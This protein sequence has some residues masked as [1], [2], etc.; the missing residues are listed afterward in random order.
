MFSKNTPSTEI[1]IS[2]SPS[3]SLPKP[4]LIDED[5]ARLLREG[6][7]SKSQSHPWITD[8]QNIYIDQCIQALQ[9]FRF[10]SNFIEQFNERWDISNIRAALFHTKLEPLARVIKAFLKKD[11]YP[12]ISYF[13]SDEQKPGSYISCNFHPDFLNLFDDIKHR[14]TVI[15]NLKIAVQMLSDKEKIYVKKR[16]SHPHNN[17][18]TTLRELACTP[19]FFDIQIIE[20]DN[21]HI[22]LATVPKPQPP[23]IIIDDEPPH[24]SLPIETNNWCHPANNPTKLSNSIT[25]IPPTLPRLNLFNEANAQARNVLQSQK[26]ISTTN[27]VLMPA[28]FF[29]PHNQP[30][31]QNIISSE[32]DMIDEFEIFDNDLFGDI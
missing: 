32:I 27:N 5:N 11:R 6:N 14:K 22:Q 7:W 16:F 23:V 10:P 8:W 2:K 4:Q 13:M 12:F 20:P 25:I 26:S 15:D 3:F 19:T 31:E 1:F 21:D 17:A 29:T 9:T 28:R 18:N 24:A 30:G